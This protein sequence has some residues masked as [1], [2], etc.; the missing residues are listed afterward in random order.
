MEFARA[1]Q[2]G[3]GK[4]EEVSLELTNNND[5]YIQCDTCPAKSKAVFDSIDC[6]IVAKVDGWYLP[7][8]DAIHLCPE[9][10]KAAKP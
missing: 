6:W 7:I 4:G 3:E 8:D 10:K 2:G 9:C 1:G 5:Y